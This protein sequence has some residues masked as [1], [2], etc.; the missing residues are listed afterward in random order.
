MAWILPTLF[1]WTM[2]GFAVEEPWTNSLGMV[3]HNIEAGQFTFGRVSSATGSAP[4]G[5]PEFTPGG[6]PDETPARKVT[7]S[8]FL[9]SESEVTVDQYRK[10]RPG[11]P[12]AGRFSPSVSGV[13]WEDANEFCKWLSEKEGK[14]HRL[15]T[16]A[17]WEYACR[18]SSQTPFSSGDLPPAHGE[19]NP[20]GIR[21]MHTGVAEWCLDWY[22]PYPL[23]EQSD[24]VGPASGL[25]RVVRGGALQD[26]SAYSG[27]GGVE[28]YYRRSANRAG[29]PPGY[30]GQHTVGFRVVQAEYPT[31]APEPVEVPPFQQGVKQTDVPVASGPD[32]K[33]PFFKVR[34]VL[35]TPPENVEEEEIAALGLPLGLLGHNHSP[36]LAACDNGDL[37]AGFFSSSRSHKAEYWPNVGLIA[38]R[39]RFGA[40]EWDPP[41]PFFDI[42]DL[43]D[44]TVLFWNDSGKMWMF[45]GGIGLAD[46]PFKWSFSLDSGASWEPMRLPLLQGPVGGYT[47]QPI[48][49]AFRDQQGAV[50]FGSDG[51]GAQS[52]LWKST[53]EGTTW[54]DTGGR[55]GGRHTVFVPLSDGGIL[56]MGGKSSN[57]EGYM[58][59]SVSNDGGRSYQ[60]SKSVFPAL[61]S[62]QRPSLIRLASGNL[63]FAGDFEDF[64]GNKP[65]EVKDSGSY[66]ALSQ[67]E[68]ETWKFRKLEAALPHESKTLDLSQ[69]WSSNK[70]SEA[71]LGYSVAC[72]GPNGMIHLLT[73]MNHPCLH[74]EFNEA[75]IQ[76][77]TPSTPA[78]SLETRQ[79]EGKLVDPQGTLRLLWEGEIGA[80]GRFRLEG[81]EKRFYEDGAPQYVATWEQG[82]KVGTE[83][84]WNA[85]GMIDWTRE[86]QPG[87]KAVWKQWWPNGQLR[88]QSHWVDGTCEGEAVLFDHHGAQEYRVTFRDG[89][90]A[91]D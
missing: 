22:G 21:N 70:H 89:R 7:V 45:W 69:E 46:V 65:A 6:D 62:N 67:N 12:D 59:Q 43:N 90:I 77:A 18:A 20:W 39:L 34:K 80:D 23:K 66:V 9:L 76:E 25:A 50:Y 57:I 32:P 3:F 61:A 27:V 26:E 8:G 16:E 19:A 41:S 28:P 78:T 56:G 48:T 49:S 17:E 38:T 86:Y 79:V 11:Y 37:L 51:L 75:W 42:P 33:V 4:L 73:T 47:P 91:D 52:F 60:V 85:D 82:L 1:P 30:R 44:Q 15:P 64:N 10:F 81:V 36:G 83:T 68:G 24:P 71:T 54:E 87:R 53:N 40:E 63:L 88:S 5:G 14:T 58:P 84:H 31:T 2:S 35:P 74:F 55:T 72:Q 29:G 13:S